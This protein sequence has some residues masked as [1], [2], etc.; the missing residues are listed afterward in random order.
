MSGTVEVGVNYWPTRFLPP[1]KGAELAQKL[2]A[3]GVVDWFQTWDQLVSFFPQALW[4]PEVTP[5][6][7]QSET[8]DILIFCSHGYAAS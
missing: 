6:A 4:R 3:A 5:M 1:Q 8:I 2:E 7:R